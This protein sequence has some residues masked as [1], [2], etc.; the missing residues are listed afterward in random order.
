MNYMD[1]LESGFRVFPL[2]NIVNGK[3][4]CENP[5][6][7]AAG[8]HPVNSG[9]QF[10]PDWS[11]EQ[12]D[13]LIKYGKFDTGWGVLC[14]GYLVID[15]DP[16]NGGDEGYEKLVKDTGID[17]KKE[18]GF[19]VQTGGNGY[20]IYFKNPTTAK[21]RKNLSDYEGIDFKTNGFVVGCGS[22]HKSGNVYEKEKG[23]PSEI[24]FS[25]NK[26]VELL[27]K[28]ASEYVVNDDESLSCEEI[29][30]YLKF[31]NPAIN[32]EDWVAIG[33]AIHYET[34]GSDEGFKLW[35]RWSREAPNYVDSEM[36]YKWHSF[37]KSDNPIKIGTV[38]K[39]A[40][41][42]GYVESVTFTPD[43]K[44]N[45]DGYIQEPV[46]TASI[47]LNH[48]CGLVGECIDFINSQCRYPREQLAVAAALS[49]VGNI[50]GL[51]FRDEE[52]GVTSNIFSF[53]VAGSATGKEAIQE[54]Q[55]T[56]H[57]AANLSK[58]TYGDVKSEQEVTRNLIKHQFNTYIIDE[59]GILLQKLESSSKSGGASYLQG[60][61]GKWMSIYSKA[62]GTYI[63]SGDAYDDLV[64]VLIKE[65]ANLNKKK[66]ENEFT[67]YD[68]VNLESAQ[69]RIKEL[70]SHGIKNPF[71]SL[72]GFT[73]G[74]TF[75]DLV[76]EQAATNGF[77]GRA[78][79][80]EEKN[81]NPKAKFGFKKKPLTNTLK[82]K[83]SN[84]RYGGAV[85]TIEPRIEHIGE[86]A[87]IKT[88]QQAI[89]LC[90]RISDYLHEYSEHCMEVN[91]LEPIVRRAFEQVLKVSMI[92]AMGDG[93]VR[94]VAHVQW[95]YALVMRDIKNK[96]NLAS[97]NIAKNVKDK[98]SEIVSKVMHCLDGSEPISAK[99][100]KNKRRNLDISQ[101]ESCLEY[102][103]SQGKVK[104]EVVTPKRGPSTIK[105]LLS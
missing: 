47:N 20:H 41:E 33:M 3:C 80:F 74:I 44:P 1:Y 88:E 105:Y 79:I 102:L 83:L 75:N 77:I 17:F 25:P 56:L 65:I 36:Q 60:V 53:C 62:D 26:L 97:G 96:I 61:I 66:D 103:C 84:L 70:E 104:K 42:H 54:A 64:N 92:L 22:L 40:E 10:T 28:K 12:L 85:K 101:I 37:G 30:K 99:A 2:H 4:S 59:F 95:A 49:A 78:L 43:E 24:N 18:S 34:E 82:M 87:M 57:S 76:T 89:E 86:H 9:W 32:Y 72:I 11:D 100:I 13:N 94:T 15:I 7:E 98:S 45:Q 21:L 5:N 23:D 91:G 93:G 39:L 55:K 19:V 8:K 48:A 58:C 52:F 46:N 67:E 81:N 16:R 29:N 38:I 35:D 69:R 14:D 50:G 63:L 27:E 73:T 31:I 51:R 71:M 68:E 90:N 6:C